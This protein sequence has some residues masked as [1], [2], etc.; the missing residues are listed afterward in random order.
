MFKREYRVH[1]S[2]SLNVLEVSASLMK[3]WRRRTGEQARMVDQRLEYERL[4]APISDRMMRTVWRIVRHPDD[5]EDA[6]QEAL[7]KIWKQWDRIRS[8][9]APHALVLRICI[10]S[11]QDLLRRQA[12]RPEA[13]EEAA[14]AD[15]IADPGSNALQQ[16]AESE[17]GREMMRAIGMLSPNQAQAI[18]LHAVEEVPYPEIAAAMAC[19][20]ATVR[21][22][23]ARA[24]AR[25]RVLLSHLIPQTAK[26]ESARV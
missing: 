15:A 2:G 23:I 4:I 5:A 25:R 12:R 10:Y 13:I 3:E 7:L 6:F 20:E 17:T 18:L 24:R 19:R 1:R 26:E 9:P 16:I 14:P 8:H 11:A 21:K 22:H